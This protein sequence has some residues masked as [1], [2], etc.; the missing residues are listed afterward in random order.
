VSRLSAMAGGP[1]Y[2]RR[3]SLSVYAVDVVD[4]D[5]QPRQ[6]SKDQADELNSPEIEQ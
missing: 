6:E 1:R 2:G 5:G 4:Q 3:R